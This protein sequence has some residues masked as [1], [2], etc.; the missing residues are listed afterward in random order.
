MEINRLSIEQKTK[1]IIM[2]HCPSVEWNI[3]SEKE[4]VF[5][6]QY[7]LSI[8]KDKKL[9]WNSGI[10]KSQE[11]IGIKCG[12][13]YEPFSQYNL[14]LKVQTEDGDCAESTLDFQT[15]HMN[16]PWHMNWIT[17]SGEIDEDTKKGVTCFQKK[18]KIPKPVKKAFVTA[19]ALGCYDL[20]FNGKLV[21]DRYFAPGYTQYTRRVQYQ[22]YDVTD[23]IKEI[24]NSP[25][26][27]HA[28]V[29]GGW[30]SGRLGL[31]LDGNRFGQKRAF[32]MEL[33][34]LYED[35]TSECFWT[36]ENWKTA[37]SKARKGAGFF[38]GEIYDARESENENWTFARILA[39]VNQTNSQTGVFPFDE[40]EWQC[41]P[42]L[43]ED[44]GEA[45]RAHEVI[46]PVIISQSEKETIFDV[47]RNLAGVVC[48]H[49]LKAKSGTR[50][51]IRHGEVLDDG[52]VYTGNL[53]TAKAELH[54][55]C[56]EGT[57]SY[58]PRFTFMG[59]RYFS[60]ETTGTAEIKA[61]NFY[62]KE[63]YS[64]MEVTGA[65]SCSN[66]LLNQLQKNILTS[67]KANFIDI[68][69]DCPQRDERCGWTGDITTFAS[70]AEYNMNCQRFLERWLA[71]VNILQEDNG[72]GFAPYVVPD[73]A[74]GRKKGGG[75][76][77]KD[78][79]TKSSAVWADVAVILPWRL[80]QASGNK[81]ILEKS[82]KGMKA[83]VDFVRKDLGDGDKDKNYIRKEGLGD[84]LAPGENII[85]NV[86]KAKW[87]STVY[88][89]HSVQIVSRAAALLGK[90]E[91]SAYYEKLFQR[92]CEAFRNKFVRHGH[93]KKGF[94]TIY[95]LCICFG[96]LKEEELTNA[97]E[98]LVKDIRKR[99]NHLSTGFAG[100]PYLA[101]AL[102]DSGNMDVAYDL[103]LQDTFPSWLYPVKVGATS[104]WERWDSL[105]PDGSI[106]SAGD[107]VSFNHY[108]YGAV[109]DF[110]YR[111]ICG[112]ETISPGYKYFRIAPKPGGNL[113][114]ANTEH[115]SPYGM[116]KVSWEIRTEA[117]AKWFYL[118]FEIPA[119]TTAEVVLPSG[120]T[121]IYG[122]GRYCVKEV[123]FTA[124]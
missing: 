101:F 88:W 93:I 75:M 66:E 38:D 91:E 119:N 59:F 78:E 118:K 23:Q 53:R 120:K 33:N 94:Q 80:Y 109:G 95:A 60:V 69:T 15:G 77:G 25:L 42:E 86:L 102:A 1:Q 106:N 111:R 9:I 47:G 65:F 99:E 12:G 87:I 67:Q 114:W 57:Q 20:Y 26:Q 7:E 110:L 71:D 76:W 62:V 41:I 14:E 56:K 30:Y 34:L 28:E 61:K 79:H 117:E 97:A 3:T 98:D 68:P 13:E 37:E 63:L 54:Y 4:N 103:L 8:K 55:T 24:Y 21:D 52:K 51:L 85:K 17:D 82:Y 115:I 122:S 49:Q 116:I 124:R 123:F 45:V 31:V 107:M 39:S 36:D 70:T 32:A 22:T 72:K 10:V 108:S 84:W 100:T 73:N 35:G 2:N 83:Q 50:I 27:I 74:M 29:S 90:N 112:L 19:S 6:K 92:I 121:E 40:K 96:I 81:Q 11:C 58:E 48:I 104:I 16:Q 5:Q 18:V 105:K 46:H 113:T 44:C 64:D 43:V 89:A